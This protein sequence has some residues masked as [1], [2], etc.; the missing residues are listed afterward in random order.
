[1]SSPPPYELASA[2]LREAGL[3]VADS[4]EPLAGGRN[5]QVFRVVLK[6]GTCVVLKCY[7]HDP[8]DPRD[9]LQAEW[10]FLSYVVARGVR[11]V[12]QPLAS[13]PA[14]HCALYNF[15]SGARAKSVDGELIAQAAEFAVAIN[16][17]PAEPGQL[18]PASEA[19][20][21]LGS[22]LETVD[23]RVERLRELDGSAPHVGEAS[24]FVAD[25]LNP[26]WQRIRSGI[27]RD[28]EVRGV[29]IAAAVTREIV[30]PSDFGF[31]NAL[32]DER[33][34]ATFLDFEYAGRD[35]PAKLICDFFCQPELAVPLSYYA[36]F[37]GRIAD[38]LS[39]EEEDLWRARL[40]LDAYRIKWVC[41]M[42]N[43]FS[44]LGA[45]RRAFAARD[46][47]SRAVHQLRN[48]ERYLTLVVS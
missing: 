22:H 42:L 33:G 21:S 37:T 9:R 10:R 16:G 32:V 38:A 23:R 34:R 1:M 20:F 26:A 47:E 30:S 27:V 6:E 8:R 39:L 40:L 19:C 17:A 5:N 4:V 45:R 2:L 43:E 44:A 15:V 41:I 36:E 11:N 28:A 31:H 7:H 46:G 14:R 12:P 48:A 3:G 29:A 24:D 18:A 13:D 35:D 25:K